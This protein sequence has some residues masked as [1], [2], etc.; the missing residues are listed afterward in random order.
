LEINKDMVAESS[1]WLA[2]YKLL[3]LI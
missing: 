3:K 2:T 1:Y